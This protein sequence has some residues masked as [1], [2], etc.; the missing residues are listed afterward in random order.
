MSKFL[1]QIY[2]HS[3]N[4]PKMRVFSTKEST[5]QEDDSYMGYSSV[6]G[7]FDGDGTQGVAVG[8]PRGAGLLGKVIKLLFFEILN[9]ISPKLSI[10]N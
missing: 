3:L 2:S 9:I 8:M 7:D 4:N 1:G 6:N 5:A 10:W